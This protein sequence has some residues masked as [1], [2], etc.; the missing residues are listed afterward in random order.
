VL[1]GGENRP[2]KPLREFD[3]R[4]IVGRVEIVLTGLVDYA[5]L[6]MFSG[7]AVGQDAIDLVPLQ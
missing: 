2:T 7:L 1:D 4:E 5:E 3:G 6:I